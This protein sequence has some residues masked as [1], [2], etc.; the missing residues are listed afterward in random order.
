MVWRGLTIFSPATDAYRDPL[1]RP[2]QLFLT[3]D[4]IYADDV[5]RV[6][7]H[8]QMELGSNFSRGS[9]NCL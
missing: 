4:Q 3:G 1:K 9:N 2:H 8:M 7:L 5:G 6:Q